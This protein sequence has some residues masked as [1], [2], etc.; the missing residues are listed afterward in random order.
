MEIDLDRHEA[1]AE[2][3][4]SQ[5]CIVGAG[6]AGLTMAHRLSLQGIEVALL[7]AGGRALGDER[8]NFFAQA[9]LSGQRHLGTIEGRFRAFGGSSLRW[10]GQVLPLPPLRYVASAVP[11]S[12]HLDASP[13]YSEVEAWPLRPDTLT[14]FYC[15]AE[16]LLEL[17][18]LPFDGGTF[19]GASRITRPPLLAQL[20]GIGSRLSKWTA[21]DRR[22]FA[23]TFAKDVETSRSVRVYLHAQ[24]V[25]LSLAASRDRIEAVRVRTLGGDEFRF[26]AEQ[27]IVAAGTVETSRLLLASRSVAVEG[28]GNAYDQ[29]GRGFHDHLTLPAATV[30]GEARTRLLREFRPW[31]FGATLHSI[32]LEAAMD[33]RQRLALNPVLAH[34]TLEEPEDTGLAVVRRILQARQNGKMFSKL[35]SNAS[36]LPTIFAETVRLAWVAKVLHRRFVSADTVVRLQLNAAQDAPSTSRITLSTELDVFGLAEPIVDWRITENELATL[37]KFA[38][39]LREHLEGLGLSGFEWAPELFEREGPLAGIEDARHAMGGA[40]MGVDPRTSVVDADLAV[41]GV[42]NLSIAGAATFP[43]GNAQLPT[44]PLMALSLRLADRIASKLPH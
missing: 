27:F 23:N 21:F 22:N 1:R 30:R 33:L 4:R 20:P 36:K 5:V 10:G 29:V 38:S 43:N 19:F 9:K 18:D 39:H 14:P 17:D 15:I 32:K 28:V 37:R 34:L 26:E 7:E 42:G 35:A 6:I 24:A 16:N 8:E 12:I 2:P 25:E 11:H 31:V 40:C 41:H 3:F 13:S 44:L